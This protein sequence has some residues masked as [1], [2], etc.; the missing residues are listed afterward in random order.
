MHN[1]ISVRDA[2]ALKH[3]VEFSKADMRKIRLYLSNVTCNK[4][5]FPSTN[6]TLLYRKTLYPNS[7]ESFLNGE[8][9]RVDYKE[10]IVSTTASMF[11]HLKVSMIY[12]VSLIWK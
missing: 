7:L 2:V 3:W 11:L 6:S 12:P 8:A 4:V 5:E 10:L 1:K 9:V